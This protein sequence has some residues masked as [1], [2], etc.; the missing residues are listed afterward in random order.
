MLALDTNV[1]LRYLV[2]DD[3]KQQQLAFELIDAY[4]GQTGSLLLNNI[5][6]CELVWVLQ[7]G[8]QYS[9]EQIADL[10]HNLLLVPELVFENYELIADSILTYKDQ[11][12]DLADILISKTNQYLGATH[13]ISFDKVASSKTLFT[14]AE[15]KKS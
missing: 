13:T 6:L 14:Y 7:S 8:Y 1:I 9:E 2:G 15:D 12:G 11:G 4:S 3:A 10:L 5:V